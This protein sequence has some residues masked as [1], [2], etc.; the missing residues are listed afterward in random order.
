MS[1]Q[2]I[3]SFDSI[4]EIFVMSHSSHSSASVSSSGFHNTELLAPAGTLLSLITGVQNGADA[5][6]MGAS[7][8]SARASAGNFSDRELTAGIDYAHA[9]GKKVYV[10][11]NTLYREDELDEVVALFSRLYEYGA[12]SFIVQDLGLLK[13][14]FEMY[15]NFPIHAST[16]MTIHNSYH[17]AFL[18]KYGVSRIVPARENSIEEL[19]AIKD[20]GV[21]V[22]TFIHG[23]IC[24]CYSG[25]CLFSSL[26][27]SRSGNRGR[28]AQPC[29]KKYELLADAKPIHTEGQYLLSP[30]DLNA[31]DHISKLMKAGIDA[32]KI[33]GRM[34][35]PE[36]VAGVVSVY[37][38]IIDRILASQK[39]SLPTPSEKE[40]LKKLFNRDFTEGYFITNPKNDLMSRKLPYNK[41]LTIGKI[42]AVDYRNA[43]I[44]I[45]LTSDLSTRDGISIGDIGKNMESVEDPRQGF[46][47]KKMFIN[48]KICDKAGA[49]DIVS[50]PAA[51]LFDHDDVPNVGDCVYKT[52][53]DL[54]QRD[55]SETIPSFEDGQLEEMVFE[56]YQFKSKTPISFDIEKQYLSTDQFPISELIEKLS[57]EK[58]LKI[59]ASFSCRIQTGSPIIIT[60]QDFDGNTISICSEYI[61]EP[62]KKNPF[63]KEQATDMLS[64][65][66]NTIYNIFSVYV[67]IEGDCF[68]PVGEFKSIR[69]KALQALLAVRI[70]KS[71]RTDPQ[72]KNECTVSQKAEECT[73]SQKQN[74]CTLRQS[75][76][77]LPFLQNPQVSV[78]VYSG[79]DLKAALKAGADRVYISHDIFRC[80]VTKEEFGILL[81]QLKS[82]L[83]DVS[84]KDLDKLFFK[85]S[86]V[87][88][89]SDFKDLEET[90]LVLQELG[91]K[92]ILVSNLGVY[93]YLSSNPRFSGV[94][95][96]A[97]DAAFNIFNSDAA[98]IFSMAGVTSVM[99]SPELSIDDIASISRG[100]IFKTNSL[101]VFEA[102]VHGRQR[103]MVTEHPLLDAVLSKSTFKNKSFSDNSSSIPLERYVLKDSKDFSFPVLSD[104]TGRCFIFNSKE[105]NAYDLLPNLKAAG[106]SIFR[107]DGIG[108]TPDEIFDLVSLYKKGLAESET[109]EFY[110]SHSKDGSEFT[111]GNFIRGVE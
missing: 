33:E 79:D 65:I 23:A 8:F 9:F 21:E 104:T 76:S 25:Q 63:T 29:R 58:S 107:I 28:C 18:K 105:L 86:F 1:N 83:S 4:Q 103:L 78:C 57:P 77:V 60:A 52:Y 45:S 53:D 46:M 15:P 85:T 27:G 101:P 61:I 82:I 50:I 68:I 51:F 87:T 106:V 38:K 10:T 88:K 96:I 39:E 69:N 84:A 89:E 30:R 72:K 48:H 6:Y 35:K 49:G 97:T 71:R 42:S 11:L 110:E 31:T 98:S 41:G 74:E 81:R 43:Q 34:K 93:E 26:V 90:F 19:S 44:N 111:K 95:K 14:L 5:I 62:A 3:V 92:N 91:I 59:N 47:I 66:G 102:A 109:N 7:R 24:I 75:V 100:Y 17:A 64:K 2:S 16:Q 40:K 67:S 70:E 20:T 94:F 80:P 55:L 22:E 99:L 108:H 13:R 73:V 37:R 12:D 32:F 56:T 54:L 36:Y